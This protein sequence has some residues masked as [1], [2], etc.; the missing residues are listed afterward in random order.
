M[1]LERFR[2]EASMDIQLLIDRHNLDYEMITHSG[3]MLSLLFIMKSQ[4]DSDLESVNT[5][6]T[7]KTL[8]EFS[9]FGE[10]FDGSEHVINEFDQIN[11]LDLV[12]AI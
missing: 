10:E 7:S 1:E 2:F 5:L 3:C 8:T 6:P 4:L 11:D 9:V 12:S